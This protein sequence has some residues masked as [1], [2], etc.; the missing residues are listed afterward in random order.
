MSLLYPWDVL[1]MTNVL[2]TPLVGTGNV[3]IL[4]LKII[5]V[6][7]RQYVRLLTMSQNVR[8]PMDTL[9]RLIQIVGHVS[10]LIY[11]VV[12]LVEDGLKIIFV[13]ITYI[14]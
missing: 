11:F 13:T 6:H 7:Q 8:V 1:K 4:A 14:C 9:A 3:S 5:L 12:V 2:F 10:N